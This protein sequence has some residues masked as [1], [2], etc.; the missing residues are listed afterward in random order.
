[1]RFHQSYLVCATPRSGSTLFCEALRSTG[2]AGYPQEYFERLKETGLPRQPQEYFS[3]LD[4]PETLAILDN[5]TPQQDTGWLLQWGG[6]AY[7][8]YLDEVYKIGTTSN[9]VFG[10]KMMWGYFADFVH[11]VRSIPCYQQNDVHDLVSGVFPHARYI[12]ITRQDK[13]AQAISLWKAIQTQRW[14]QESELDA[15]LEKKSPVFH[16]AAIRHLEQQILDNEAAWQEYFKA[17]AT[18]PLVIVYEELIHDYEGTLRKTFDYLAIP[19][20]ENLTFVRPPMIRQAN[21][22]SNTWLL[23]YRQFRQEAEGE[24]SENVS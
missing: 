3:T 5:P 13:A 24:I 14:R 22:L 10:A 15:S 23:H 12:W 7:A 19:L 6:P 8:N 4:D 1:M 21:E 18:Q 16:F 11:L 2:L 17:C 9:G 20:P